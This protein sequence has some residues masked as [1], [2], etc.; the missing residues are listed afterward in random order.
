L[1]AQ[2][3]AEERWAVSDGEPELSGMSLPP[4]EPLVPRLDELLQLRLKEVRA[5]QEAWRERAACHE[6]L[7]AAGVPPGELPWRVAWLLSRTPPSA[8]GGQGGDR[9]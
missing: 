8:L 5:L 1:S 6:R 9:G 7:T 2:D 3:R 4:E